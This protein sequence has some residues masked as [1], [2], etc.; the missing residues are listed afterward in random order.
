MIPESPLGS[1]HQKLGAQLAPY[2]GCLL[3]EAFTH[4]EAECRVARES[5]ALLDATYRA[6]FEFTGPDRIRYLNAVLTNN[7]KDLAPGQGTVALLLNPQG[8]ILAELECLV[9]EEKVVAVSHLLVRERAAQTLEKYIIMDDVTLED[10]TDRTVVLAVEGPKA[11]EL[12]REFAG[13][14]LSSMN[15]FAHAATNLAGIP[16]RVVRRSHFGETGADIYA[17][18]AQASALWQ[19]LLAAVRGK[20]GAPIGYQA[21]NILRLEAGIPWFGYDF[22]DKVIPHEAGLEQSHISY[23][24]GCYTGQEIVERVRS[25]GHANRRRI[26]LSFPGANIPEAGTKLL[27]SG[28]VVGYVTSAAYSPR[29]G[30]VIGMGYLRREYVSP[31][32]VVE[33]NLGTAEVS[34]G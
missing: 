17:D 34:S 28:K 8:H 10:A 16:C 6:V 2:F 1:E 13:L 33:W 20:G 4:T 30:R 19:A 26:C 9:L 31:G 7:V 11:A 12:V 3:P 29:S 22:D 5:V 32:T 24:K 14:E 25:R 21:V 23:T 15:K 18:R 27:A